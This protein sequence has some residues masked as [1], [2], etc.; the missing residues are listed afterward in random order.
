MEIYNGIY[1]VY[2]HTNKINGKKYVGQT[3]QRPERRWQNGYGY[4]KSPHFW[5]AIQK[6]GW[7]N[8]E[9]EIIA[10]NLTKEEADNFEKLLINRLD[11]QGRESGYN[12]KDGG[13][14]GSIPEETRQKIREANTGRHHSD[15]T[16]KQMSAMKTG[17]KNKFYGK[18]H[19][20]T[21]KRKISESIKRSP[22]NNSKKVYQYDL[23]ENFLKE[24][25]NMTRVAEAYNIGRTTVMNHC[26]NGKPINGEFILKLEKI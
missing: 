4:E 9:H 24:W 21:S 1:C 19:S 26:R 7:D 5:R 23:Q 11:L 17:D 25:D 20:D 14:Y 22:N 6:Y 8:F 13:S 18:H 16:K 3:G 10:S 2:V 15:E 12:L